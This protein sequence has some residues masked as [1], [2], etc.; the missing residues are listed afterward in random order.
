MN[1]DTV[2]VYYLLWKYDKTSVKGTSIYLF[3]GQ[4]NQ[5]KKNTIL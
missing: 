1:F 5:Q 3:I 4:Q 2:Q